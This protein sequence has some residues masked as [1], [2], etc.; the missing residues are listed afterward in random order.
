[1]IAKAAA[2]VISIAIL[3]PAAA[4]NAKPERAIP[5]DTAI[6]KILAERVKAIAGTD[7]GIGIVVGI[8]SSSGRRTISY[9]HSGTGDAKPLTGDTP[10]EIGSVGKV[11]TALLL[12]DMARR[13]ELVLENPAST[14]LPAGT[15]LP[16]HNGHQISLADLAT[17]TSG[18]PF[19]PDTYPTVG[20]TDKF[21]V[22]DAYKFLARY[23][24]KRDPGTEWEYS[25]IDYWLLGETMARRAGMPFERLLENRIF[26]PLNMRS[27]AARLPETSRATVAQGHDAS[28]QPSVPFYGISVYS[29]M[30]A[31]AGGIY[32]SA[33]DL[34]MFISA[35]LGL[36]RSP[37]TASIDAMLKT[38]RPINDKQQA[39]GWV[40]E[41]KGER[42]FIFHD[43]GTWGYA[44]AVAL[45]PKD[46][47]GVVVLSNQQE[48][49]ADIARHLLRP[50]IPLGIPR[51][52]KHNEIP[53]PAA[54]LDAYAGR[55][56]VEDVGIFDIT[57]HGDHLALR[58]PVDWGLPEFQLHP[59]SKQ[60]FF[61]SEMP[62]H[63][64]FQQD[65]NGNITGA[66]I[67][68]PRGQ[69]G[70]SAKRTGAVAP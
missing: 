42:Q 11:F 68:P 53:M 39:L 22:R 50:E 26:G 48:S 25:N 17:H 20:D 1:M 27:T 35:M 61:V 4:Q 29:T 33:N 30:G 45:D 2:F 44:S 36:T 9:G 59:E 28:L 51:L 6:R 8:V 7:D 67:Y 14:Y 70:I 24:L 23:E 37:L 13:G 18:L 47:F 64:S 62:V 16:Q 5:S 52:A 40:V 56:A 31:A 63:V 21:G 60:E 38:Q 12:A 65:G 55:Y 15:K 69:H 49:V 58:V 43:G 34:G 57:N 54:A 41:G 10:F 66:L 3:S 46:K 32:S 19:M